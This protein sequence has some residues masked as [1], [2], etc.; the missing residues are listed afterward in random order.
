MHVKESQLD[1]NAFSRTRSYMFG[2]AAFSIIAFHYSYDVWKA[3]TTGVV[4]MDESLFYPVFY[5]YKILI[6]SIGVEVFLFLSG[7]GLYY[8][9]SKDPDPA[10]FYRKRFTRVL[11]PYLLCAGPYWYVRDV[12]LREEELIRVPM[13]FFFITFFKEG[14][15]MI[16]FICF[17][18]LG[19]LFYPLIYRFLY[20]TEKQKQHAGILLTAGIALPVLYYLLA[21][22]IFVLTNIASLRIPIFLLGCIMAKPIKEHQTMPMKLVW[23]IIAASFVIRLVTCTL[24]ISS[25][26]ARYSASLFSIGLMLFL[27]V[28]MDGYEQKRQKE[29]RKENL[30]MRV[31]NWAGAYSLEFYLLH[32]CIRNIFKNLHWN[33]YEPQVYLIV[34]VATIPLGVILA[35]VSKTIQ[36]RI[37]L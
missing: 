9:Y 28:L 29:Q 35:K 1:L 13:D 25:V 5:A 19:Y 14:Q 34:V 3:V 22:D 4:M 2:L 7:M 33:V 10:R 36:T 21:H 6:R 15:R 30:L 17:I 37:F 16:W 27:V 20:E 26:F 24:N 23:I 12:I 11:I 31:L 18:V 32:V 8:S